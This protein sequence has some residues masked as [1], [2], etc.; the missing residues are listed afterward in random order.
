[1][2]DE[3]IGFAFDS[4]GA[5]SL[6]VRVYDKAPATTLADSAVIGI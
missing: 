2:I 3:L 6:D 1:V 4:L 5:W